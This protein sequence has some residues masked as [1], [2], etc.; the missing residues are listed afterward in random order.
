MNGVGGYVVCGRGA[1]TSNSIFLPSAGVAKGSKRYGIGSNGYYWS[2]VPRSDDD[3]RSWNLFF[4]SSDHY[5]SGCSRYYG[6]S[7]R[8]VQGFTR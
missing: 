1:Y 4:H 2:S 7:I 5:T 8:P 3:N 6:Q